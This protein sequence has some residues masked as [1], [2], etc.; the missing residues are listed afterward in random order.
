MGLKVG[1]TD[2][3]VKVKM[4]EH[5]RKAFNGTDK[6][7]RVIG[8]GDSSDMYD[9]L[10]PLVVRM[11]QETY[12]T[13]TE[14]IDAQD[15]QEVLNK[16]DV[17]EVYNL[18]VLANEKDEGTIRVQKLGVG[19]EGSIIEAGTKGTNVNGL[20]SKAKVISEVIINALVKN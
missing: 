4:Y 18:V 6:K 9:A 1:S 15:V 10:G 16:E 3:L 5:L 13:G 17:Q 12:L 2:Y 19:L 7:I 14:V 8:V 20:Y 11:L